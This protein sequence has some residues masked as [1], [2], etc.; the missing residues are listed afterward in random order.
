MEGLRGLSESAAELSSGGG[1]R[2]ILA[3]GED[4]EVACQMNGDP[5]TT[6]NCG[7]IVLDRTIGYQCV[8]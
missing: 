3:V 7:E 5:A 8:C 2:D 4:C 1:G 6:W